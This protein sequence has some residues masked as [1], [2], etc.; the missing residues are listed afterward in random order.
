MTWI[1]TIHLISSYKELLTS[2][3]DN[4]IAEVERDRFVNTN[5]VLVDSLS[6][7]K[8]WTSIC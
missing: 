3:K 7:K 4:P 6:K 2:L 8:G 1:A 5:E